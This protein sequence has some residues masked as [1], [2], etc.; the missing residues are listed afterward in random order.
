MGTAWTGPDPYSDEN[1]FN[2]R[3]ISS[4]GSDVVVRLN[5]KKD[6][7]VG[8]LG[9]GLRTTLMSYFLRF[10]YA[11]GIEDGVFLKPMPMLSIGTDF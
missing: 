11:W 1:S 7:L 6:P 3:T 5:N 2:T 8:A 9:F 4:G 10:D